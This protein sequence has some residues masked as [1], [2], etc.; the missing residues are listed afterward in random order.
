[1]RDYDTAYAA[2]TGLANGGQGALAS[3][4][5]Q[6]Q[7]VDAA[8]SAPDLPRLHGALCEMAAHVEQMRADMGKLAT[9]LFGPP[10]PSPV[11]QGPANAA[12]AGI[13]DAAFT[14]ADNLRAEL[15]S[16]CEVLQ[17]FRRLA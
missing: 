7:W 16:L 13:V 15:G 9:D 11:P 17:R 10:P 4:L 5:A 2:A 8:P 14:A 6:P 1:M 12:G 3:Q